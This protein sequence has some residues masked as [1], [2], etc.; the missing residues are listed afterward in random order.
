[1]GRQKK[2]AKGEGK[3]KQGMK[4][5]FIAIAGNVGVGKSTLTSML[6]EKLGWEPFL[7][8]GS[9]FPEI[10][11]RV[12]NGPFRGILHCIPVQHIR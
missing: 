1:M 8:P 6:A 11:L 7:Q 10:S 3:E 2:I 9:H 4:K 12:N 5:H